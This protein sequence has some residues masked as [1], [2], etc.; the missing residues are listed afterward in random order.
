MQPA[1]LYRARHYVVSLKHD[2][3]A[4][5]R[6]SRF[7]GMRCEIQIQTTLNHAWSETGPRHPLQAAR[8]AGLPAPRSSREAIEQAVREDN[9]G[10]SAT[11]RIRIPE[12]QARL[13]TP[14]G[15]RP[16]STEAVIERLEGAA[17]NVISAG[18]CSKTSAS[19]WFPTTTTLPA[20]TRNSC[21]LINA[22]TD[23]RATPVKAIETDF[24]SFRGH[25]SDEVTDAALDI[26]IFFAS[27]MV[28]AT[29][30]AL[31]R[32]RA[33]SCRR[34][35]GSV[36]MKLSRRLSQNNLDAWRKVGPAIQTALVSTVSA[37]EPDE[38]KLH[39]P[40][41]VSVCSNAMRSPRSLARRPASHTVTF[42]RGAV[43][44]SDELISTRKR[45]FSILHTLYAEA[46]DDER[47]GASPQRDP[48][49]DANAERLRQRS[50]Q[51]DPRRRELDCAVLH[52]ARFAADP[53][54][55][56]S[57]SR[58]VLVDV[59]PQQD[60]AC[61]TVCGAGARHGRLECGNHPLQR[62][63]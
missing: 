10:L 47:R 7:A 5:P 28:D 39:F 45:L 38:R 25:T 19:T 18:T 20:Y 27:S 58:H 48:R 60:G 42:H 49:G 24:G 22:V 52:R 51:G 16:S 23:G 17:D 35:E 53:S 61:R 63:R 41:I 54:R 14:H 59:S 46:E 32:D 11:R 55:C 34:Q 30:E 21:A 8:R 33:R 12:D 26:W 9:E 15:G 40:V 3:L 2:R 57:T 1:R 29:F 43:V 50:P 44:V 62:H 6:Y 56:C 13:R 37:F 4:L 31:C 36:L